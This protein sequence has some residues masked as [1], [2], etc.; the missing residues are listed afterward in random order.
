MKKKLVAALLAAQMVVTLCPTSSVF[1]TT[2]DDTVAVQQVEIVDDS[3]ELYGAETPT[4]ESDF[5]WDGNTITKYNGTRENVVLPSRTT[6]IGDYAFLDCRNLKS[7]TIPEKVTSIGDG[8]FRQCYGITSIVI[9]SRVDTIG[10]D[11]FKDCTALSSFE[12][13]S[14]VLQYTG[15]YGD[16]DIFAGCESLKTIK[17]TGKMKYIPDA[18]F[19]GA[20]YLES[21]VI[22][23][24][25]TSIGVNSFNSCTSLQQI[26]IPK[27]VTIIDDSAFEDCNALQSISLPENLTKLGNHVFS[28]CRNLNNLVIPSRVESIGCYAFNDCNSLSNLEIKSGVLENTGYSGTTQL[29]R[30]CEKLKTV[31]LTGNMKYIP[32]GMFES[33]EYLET[34]KIPSTVTAI[35]SNAFSGCTSLQQITIPEAV[36]SIGNSAFANCSALTSLVI[37]ANVEDIG[38]YA[39]GRCDNL[40]NVEIKSDNLKNVGISGSTSIFKDCISLEKV[41]MTGKLES[42]PSGMF[43]DSQYIQ[44]VELPSTIK[45][46]P[47]NAFKNCSFLKQITIPENVTAIGRYA[48]KWCSSLKEV[49]IPI[50]V[51]KLENGAFEGCTQLEKVTVQNPDMDFHMD[52][53]YDYDYNHFAFDNFVNIIGYADSTAKTFA[54]ENGINFIECNNAEVKFDGASV[55][56]ADTIGLNFYVKMTAA[57]VKNSKAYMT[58]QLA[59]GTV[60][61]VS[62][63]DTKQY[64][65]DENTRVFTCDMPA[66]EM[67][68]II[69]AQLVIPEADGTK[70][71]SDTITYSVKKY[72]Q[73]I[74]DNSG[75]Y[76]AYDIAVIKKMLNYGSYSQQFFN[77]N[78][79]NLANDMLDDEEQTLKMQDN[80]MKESSTFHAN[81]INGIKYFGKSLLLKSKTDM[82][83]YFELTDSTKKIT[84]YVFKCDGK[85]LKPVA[86]GSIYYVDI[87]DIT[88][89]EY[90]KVFAVTVSGKDFV[91]SSVYDYCR[92]AVS[93]NTTDGKL[94]NLSVSMYELGTTIQ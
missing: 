55:T 27:S 13:K 25:V 4:P 21:I 31:L 88:P 93:S 3:Q 46:I 26:T 68:D 73:H 74:L 11:A 94:K 67:S 22:P 2:V 59:D 82:R 44:R 80:L 34:L 36:T 71:L 76:D 14:N 6:A 15:K 92:N 7:V 79:E 47:S 38:Y 40:S 18:M 70:K 69:K 32:D 28:R 24:S 20:D 39:F 61:K 45:E 10:S 30:G 48:F 64:S 66:A 35:S 50:N 37:P 43:A 84:D 89:A 63:T 77:Y 65:G 16:S 53:Y 58:F 52:P 87:A 9:P 23:D 78:M 86:I 1:A 19:E 72:C 54:D 42:I 8:A 51:E 12:I 49:T 29:F 62:I 33:A 56:L 57:D 5:T 90:G 91:S 81:N 83:I 41:R 17:L 60:R 85:V 75:L